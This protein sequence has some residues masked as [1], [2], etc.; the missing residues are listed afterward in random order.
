MVGPGAIVE[1]A[2]TYCHVSYDSGPHFPTE[3][4]FDTVKCPM[5]LDLASQLRWAPT[6]PRALRFRTL[7]LS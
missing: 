6:L 2:P 3:V 5:S 1:R 7:P 4:G